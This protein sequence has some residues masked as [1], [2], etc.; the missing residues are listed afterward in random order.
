M[1]DVNVCFLDKKTFEKLDNIIQ[2]DKGICDTI[3]VLN[4]K[5]YRTFASC[6]GHNLLS[7]YFRQECDVD[8]LEGL[9]EN[10]SFKES[11]VVDKTDKSFGLVT[12]VMISQIYIMFEKEYDFLLLPETFTYKDKTL[13]SI[14]S[15]YKNQK[16]I[17][18]EELEQELKKRNDLL[19]KWANDLPINKER[20]D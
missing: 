5:G 15:Y 2:V 8:L 1:N 11:I 14:V 10:E 6:S 3:R 7:K 19:L 16:R 9:Y 17:T 13:E 12:P 4:Q 20:N 18:S